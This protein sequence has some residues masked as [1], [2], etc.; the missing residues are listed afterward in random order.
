VI[1]V[2]FVVKKKTVA[3]SAQALTRQIQPIVAARKPIELAAKRAQF[4]APAASRASL[5]ESISCKR[6]VLK[7]KF[8]I[9]Q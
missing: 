2:F 4:Q 7:R 8:P 3:A 1:Y 6:R 9:I 5:P